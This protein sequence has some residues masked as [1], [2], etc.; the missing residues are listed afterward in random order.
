MNTRT[1]ALLALACTLS[2]GCPAAEETPDPTPDA[3]AT[4][5]ASRDAAADT[6][7]GAPDAGDPIEDAGAEDATTP[8][9]DAGEEPGFTIAPG[10]QRGA[11]ESG[12]RTREFNVRLP[13][14]Y[15]GATPLPLLL[16]FH[17]G[18]GEGATLQDALGFDAYTDRDGAIAVY[19]DGVEKNWA[20]GRGTT[21]ASQAGV[22]D[23]G[24]VADLIDHLSTHLNV[25]D[26]KVW[27]TGVSNGGFFTQ[28][29]ACELSDR[30]DAVAPVISAL[31]TAALDTC[32]PGD[33][34]PMLAIQGTEDQFITFAGGDASHDTLGLGDGG[35]IESADTTRAF[36]AERYGCDPTPT[37][38]ALDPVDPQDPTRA[39]LYAYRGCDADAR[40]DYYIV[41]GMGHTW[42]PNS[43]VA[44]RV[45][46]PASPQLDATALIWAFF[47]AAP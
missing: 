7:T 27:A 43:G 31:P 16:V 44:P 17:G 10:T 3:A 5:D 29:L 47:N 12:G 21:D 26:Q 33:A 11:I 2:L 38:T 40:I 37:V 8:T 45:S 6:S 9:E 39:E 36:W 41:T 25:D 24:F 28:H 1:H 34:L 46:G 22:D 23:I 18:N 15:D 14:G 35:A 30:I 13:P 4:P 19:P 42:P 20:D 32:R